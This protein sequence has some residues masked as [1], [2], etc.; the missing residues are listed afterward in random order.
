MR[1]LEARKDAGFT[2]AAAALAPGARPARPTVGFT[3]ATTG[4][5]TCRAAAGMVREKSAERDTCAGRSGEWNRRRRSSTERPTAVARGCGDPELWREPCDCDRL[6]PG[7]PNPP[8]TAP[9]Y[10]ATAISCGPR[11]VSYDVQTSFHAM[12]GHSSVSYRLP[13]VP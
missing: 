11:R 4:E 9:W 2:A 13:N 10:D 8:R 1:P 5:S 6:W 3:H 12:H 7:L